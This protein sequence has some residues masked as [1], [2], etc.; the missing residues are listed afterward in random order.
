M[1]T[2][3]IRS[4]F[5]AVTN[6]L[7]RF[8]RLGRDTRGLALTEF[9][10][11]APIFLT[12]VLTGLELSN[13][14]LAHLKISQMA[15]TVADNAGRITG[16][17]RETDIYEVFASAEYT[18]DGLDFEPHGRLILSSLQHNDATKED[19]GQT[20]VWQRC[21]GN[22]KTIRP[23]YG[24]EGDGKNDDSLKDGL[25]AGT[26]KITA[27]KDT[28]VMF[29]EVTYH[30]QPLVSTAFFTPPTI[31]YES[32]FNTRAG[33]NDRPSKVPGVDELNC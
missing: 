25:G 7:H 3:K 24:K 6:L 20:I 8:G 5:V 14:A 15:M 11:A 33:K 30:Y 29:V 1:I 18:G 16:G 32:A 21:W 17:L 19:E 13:L 23:A 9:A 4:R 26:S 2:E 10:F 22:D 27:L 28:A 31:R 12:L